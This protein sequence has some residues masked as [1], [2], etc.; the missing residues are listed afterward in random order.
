MIVKKKDL[1]L[2]EVLCSFSALED[3]GA[4]IWVG[5]ADLA[6][7]ELTHANAIWVENIFLT[8]SK[9]DCL[10]TRFLNLLNSTVREDAFLFT[11]LKDALNSSIR[12]AKKM[13]KIL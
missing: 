3:L 12:E 2:T 10:Y 11:I 13:T 1:T 4:P 5:L 8:I 9:L 7:R 6:V